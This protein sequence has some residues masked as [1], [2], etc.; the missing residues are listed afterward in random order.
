MPKISVIVPVYN[1][2][3]YISRCIESVINQTF[4]D[5]ELILVD[6][7]SCDNSG[8]ICDAYALRDDR[9]KV[10][11]TVNGGVSSARNYGIIHAIGE[12]LCFIDS[13]DSVDASYLSDFFQS[14]GN[15]DFI[16]QGYKRVVGN[17][18]LA[19]KKF[20]DESC[21]RSNAEIAAASE[22]LCIINSPCM[23]LYKREIVDAYELRFDPKISYGEDHLFSLSYL[24]QS[25]HISCKVSAGYNYYLQQGESLTSR[26]IPLKEFVYY[27]KKS[28]D[29]QLQLLS[30]YENNKTYLSAINQV[31]VNH[32][33]RIIKQ[34]FNSDSAHC[35]TV[36]F[37]IKEIVFG[38]DSYGLDFKSSVLM[39]LIKLLPLSV[40]ILLLKLY[41]KNALK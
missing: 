10:Y 1:V 8:M 9:I 29:L 12:W 18:I 21:Y 16:M 38:F 6:D 36:I 22:L 41:F 3:N 14:D 35:R 31:F 7:G 37:Q 27:L 34:E 15:Y 23:K 2:E 25:F 19:T 39:Y 11:H 32:I 30:K 33:V 17:E 20:Q 13:D 4:I 28:R 5:W 24:L 40:A 26:K